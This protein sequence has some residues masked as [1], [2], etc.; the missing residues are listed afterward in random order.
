MLP[1]ARFSGIARVAPP[2]ERPDAPAR[3]TEDTAPDDET[4]A[5]TPAR[6]KPTSVPPV[7]G[8]GP[9]ALLHPLATANANHM[10]N[11]FFMTCFLLFL[12]RVFVP[13]HSPPPRPFP[14]D[15]EGD[16][17]RYRTVPIARES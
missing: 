5:L 2:D 4:S 8:A 13:P 14:P 12:F 16:I 17:F 10:M 15:G 3:E 6:L 11:A 9:S 7:S 1:G